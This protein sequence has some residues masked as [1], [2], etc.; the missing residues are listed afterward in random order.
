MLAI[1][2]QG[3]V[4]RAREHRAVLILIALAIVVRIGLMSLYFPALLLAVDSPRYARAGGMP[5]F[6]DFW[7]PAGY[8]F[9]LCLLRRVTNE[10]WITIAVQHA[11][12]IVTGVFLYIAVVGL[13]VRRGG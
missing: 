6:G 8:P 4:E 3:F 13:Q 7:M 2:H 12:G 10:L 11:L 5:M 1:T 9:F